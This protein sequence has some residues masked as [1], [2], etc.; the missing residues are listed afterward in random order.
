[1]NST[2]PQPSPKG[3]EPPPLGEVRR[4]FLIN[5]TPPQPSPKG[6]EPPPLGEVRRGFLIHLTSA[7]QS[8]TPSPSAPP[9]AGGEESFPPYGGGD[10]G[11][12]IQGKRCVW[13]YP[14]HLFWHYSAFS[15]KILIYF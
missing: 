2:P 6:R 11:V 4:G 5:S 3:R 14:L 1:M 13:V 12:V 10:Q 8:K 15:L 7:P 9:F